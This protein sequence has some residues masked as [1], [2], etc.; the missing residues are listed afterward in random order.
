ML[1]AVA[2][3]FGWQF[4]Y[5]DVDNTFLNSAIVEGIFVTIPD[6]GRGPSWQV[7]LCL[8]GLKSDKFKQP[9]GCSERRSQVRHQKTWLRL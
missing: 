6:G 9:D 1:L 3:Y 4:D 2:A 5:V 8:Q 7:L